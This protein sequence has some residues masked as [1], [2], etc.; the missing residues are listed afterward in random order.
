M[1]DNYKQLLKSL[2]R[3]RSKFLFFGLLRGIMLLLTIVLSYLFLIIFL[4]YTVYLSPSFKTVIFYFSLLS[5]LFVFLWLIVWPFIQ[6]L[7]FRKLHDPKSIALVIRK[8]IPEL[9]DSIINTIELA[10]KSEDNYSFELIWA[11][12]DQKIEQLKLFDF[13]K[14]ISFSHLRKHFLRFLISSVVFIS[15]GLLYQQSVT[16]AVNRLIQFQ[17]EFI[18]PAPFEFEL[19]TIDLN[20]R[21]GSGLIIEMN[22]SGKQIPEIASICFGGNTFLMKK[23]DNDYSYAI[24]NIN[25]SFE[26]YFRADNFHSE[27]YRI[28]VMEVPSILGFTVTIESPAYTGIKSETLTNIGDI[29]VAHGSVITWNFNCLDTDSLVLSIDSVNYQVGRKNNEFVLSRQFTKSCKY[30][31]SLK[32]RFFNEDDVFQYSVEIIP[33]LFPEI[34]V[35]QLKDSVH[36]TRYYFKGKISDDFG[37]SKLIFRVN[38]GKKDS[39]IDVPFTKSLIEQN[40]YFTCDFGEFSKDIETFNYSF[41]VYDNDELQGFK[42]TSSEAFHFKMPNRKDKQLIENESVKE[43]ENLMNKSIELNTDIRND[44]NMLKMSQVN[45]E[46]TDW[47]KQQKVK[48]IIEKRQNLENILEQIHDKNKE[49]DHF[50]NSFSEEKKEIIEK[51]K[52]L[53]E[54]L[55]EV[56]SDDLKK[57][58][59]EFNKLA[60]DFNS[61]K[62]DQLTENLDMQLNDLSNQLDRNLQMFRRM[63]VIQKIQEIVNELKQNHE[64]EIKLSKNFKLSVK[65][66]VTLE[67]QKKIEESIQILKQDYVSVLELNK[68]LMKPLN[69]FDFTNDFNGIGEKINYLYGLIDKGRRNNSS[70]HAEEIAILIENLAFSMQKMLDNLNQKQKGEDIENIRQ[71]LDNLVYLSVF[72]EQVMDH[73]KLIKD[74]DPAIVSIKKEQLKIIDQS[75]SVSDS[76]YALAERNISLSGVV[77]KELLNVRIYATQSLKNTED[78]RIYNAIIDQQNTMMAL[79]NLALFISEVI[80]Q[81][82]DQLNNSMDSDQQCDKPGKGKKQSM[83]MLKQSQESLKKQLQQMIEKMKSGSSEGMSRQLGQTLAQQE[84][85]QQLIREM[86]GD[87][88]VGSSA[89][90]QLKMVDQLLEQNKLDIITKNISNQTINRQNLILNKLLE[91]EL[92]EMERDTDEKRESNTASDQFLSNPNLFFEYKREN[93]KTDERSQVGR[94]KL[95]KFYESKYHNYLKE[96]NK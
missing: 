37:F 36:F 39:I 73:L 78:N 80:K 93:I 88:N 22:L 48:E 76:L 56:M 47:E 57:L 89:K 70:E 31:L 13:N 67:I 71:L 8:F 16:E 6:I 38:D 92:A 14:A 95:E 11:G 42:E 62:L 46:L 34:E 21:K 60:Q 5:V 30:K 87:N 69:L 3:F 12:I 44:I 94:F 61:N 96:L 63:K 84:I 17:T 7:F 18:K 50:K 54:L 64:K 58:F 66:S 32:N 27:K 74:G 29:Q 86:M 2:N 4:E 15:L 35:V 9:D 77:N 1:T 33:D 28:N 53:D 90:E 59:D 68:S 45:G 81:M 79:N 25:N 85:M 82:E 41:S 40:F 52:E 51:Q 19:K 55:K 24:D 65:D 75:Q 72:Q 26:F 43:L 10:E 20:V 23:S 91:A 83:D 49:L